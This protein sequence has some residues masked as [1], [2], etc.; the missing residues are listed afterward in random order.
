MLDTTTHDS[1]A[2]LAA[3]V[4]HAQRVRAEFTLSVTTP[5]QFHAVLNMI[6][7]NNKLD[8]DHAGKVLGALVPEMG[9]V[10][11]HS[12]VGGP[13][14]YFQLPFYTY[15]AIRGRLADDERRRYTDQE[16][17]DLAQRVLDLGKQLHSDLLRVRQ[18]GH[19]ADAEE[20]EY[21]RP[22]THPHEVTLWWD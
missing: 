20:Y 11:I 1:P 12:C 14:L 9:Q 4:Q 2:Q 7:D 17:I 13:Y 10:R 15:Q 18:F 22:G 21:R 8:A 5:E 3:F 16:R 19:P 6:G